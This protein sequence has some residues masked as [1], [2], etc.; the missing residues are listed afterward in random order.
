MNKEKDII[1]KLEDIL[2]FKN[3]L[4]TPLKK[5]A[6]TRKRI[7]TF[8]ICILSFLLNGSYGF[9]LGISHLIS[10]MFVLEV[11]TNINK[12]PSAK[13]YNKACDKIPSQAIAELVN[14]SYKLESRSNEELFHGLKVTVVDGTHINVQRTEETIETFGLGSGTTGDAHYPQ[15]QTVGFYN[16]STGTFEEVISKY[17]N[18]PERKIMQDHAKKNEIPTL[19]LADAGYNGMA[20]I[21]MIKT[22][23]E[24]DILMQLKM[25][26]AFAKK[27]LASKKR[28]QIF[29]IKLTKVHLRNY[30]ELSRLQGTMLKIR[31]I[32][33]R[34]TTKLRSQ[35]LITTLIDEKQFPWEELALL[36]LQRY[37]VELAFRHLKS[38]IGIEKIKK[39]K[40]LRIE[41]LLQAGVLLF[42][43]SVILRNVVKQNSL[44]PK[45]KG[46]K[47][48]CPAV[49][50]EL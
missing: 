37:K 18:T 2:N 44:L 39:Q 4:E 36:Y 48:Y 50:G 38:S 25:G 12:I 1:L 7:F 24:Q 34:G 28:S 13:G 14:I 27:F 33:T 41:Q 23:F 40:I 16:L 47:V 15:T 30:S 35:L 3:K 29:E 20:H 26:T 21:A 8:P 11:W 10:K 19:Y 9:S 46:I 6:F 17:I 49:L 5:G 42:N 32:R 43:I 45:K 31:L 22:L